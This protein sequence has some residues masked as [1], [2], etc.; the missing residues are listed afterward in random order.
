M[1]LFRTWRLHVMAIALASLG[2]VA[3]NADGRAE[4]ALSTTARAD[5]GHEIARVWCAQCHVVEPEGAGFAQSDVPT[6]D[7]I[8][9]RAGISVVRIENFLTDPHPPMPNLHLSRQEMR[10]LA[11]YILSLKQQNGN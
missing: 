6:F 1:H 7:E 11:T 10:N 3:W 2:Y 5:L 8:A 4:T 9:N